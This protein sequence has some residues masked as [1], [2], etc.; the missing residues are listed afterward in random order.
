MGIYDRDYMRSES[1]QPGFGVTTMIRGV[2]VIIAFVFAFACLRI[3]MPFFGRMVLVFV[4]TGVLW[5][6]FSIPRKIESDHLFQQ[7]RQLERNGNAEAA[8][9]SYEQALVR[10]PNNT[11][12]AL[13]LL[14]TY[15]SA[16]QI[17]KAKDLIQR[18]NGRIFHEKE[19]E[20]LEAIVTQ[21]R[22]VPF[23]NYGARQVMRLTD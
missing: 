13:R 8:V 4:A 5:W 15:N 19:I 1:A 14:A 2:V 22:G 3:P 17:N 7:G 18:L 12:T 20:E 6:L 11:T 16:L 21:Y 23:E 9:R 10:S